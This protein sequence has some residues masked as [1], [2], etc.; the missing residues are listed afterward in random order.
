[1]SIQPAPNLARD[2]VNRLFGVLSGSSR[3]QAP[4]PEDVL[5]TYRD[6]L[7][8]EFNGTVT[9][10]AHGLSDDTITPDE[11]ELAFKEAIRQH[12]LS[13]AVVGAGGAHL[14]TPETYAQAQQA[15]DVQMGY[16]DHWM[17]QIR[18]GEVFSPQ[19][20]A[21]RAR[22]YGEFAGQTYERSKVQA[23]GVPTLPFYPKDRTLCRVGCCCSW[24]VEVVRGS[25]N[26]NVYWELDPECDHCAVCVARERACSPIRVRAGIILNPEK[27]LAANLY[28]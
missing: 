23:L 9:R 12:E 17:V 15:V 10:L 18:S 21:N 19:Q 14:A 20:M 26:Y 13:S 4:P 16:F 11:F 7:D 8:S 3:F 5:Q 25:S 27:Y 6:K 24:R 28:A 22:M 2:F 1:M